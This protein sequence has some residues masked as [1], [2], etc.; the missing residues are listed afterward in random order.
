MLA[1]CLGFTIL[2]ILVNIWS[3]AQ[4][5]KYLKDN[6]EQIELERELPC[7]YCSKSPA[8]P[9]ICSNCNSILWGRINSS[10][11]DVAIFIAQHRWSLITGIF[12]LFLIAPMSF[13]YSK[14]KE[15]EK[16]KY[17]LIERGNK[18]IDAQNKF[19]SLISDY[20]LSNKDGNISPEKLSELASLHQYFSW[21]LPR[22]REDISKMLEDSLTMSHLPDSTTSSF[23]YARFVHSIIVLGDTI[24]VIN[25][26]SVHTIHGTPQPRWTNY[27]ESVDSASIDPKNERL[28]R[29]RREN[30][31]DL[32]IEFRVTN[33][34]IREFI[35]QLQDSESN[36]GETIEVFHKIFG[37]QLEN[38]EQIDTSTYLIDTVRNSYKVIKYPIMIKKPDN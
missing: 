35:R 30:A 34:V 33:A 3:I 2:V 5:H 12:A 10:M 17:D 19:R 31:F 32:D 6:R 14:I 20:E 18:F 13:L 24:I 21:E 1:N 25:K 15:R 16:D 7:D 37:S 23:D 38:I 11:A 29:K 26:D 28:I 8:G 9:L 22:L 4:I 27:L 36:S